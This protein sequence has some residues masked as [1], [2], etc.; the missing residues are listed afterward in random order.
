[1]IRRLPLLVP[2][3][4]LVFAPHAVRT[5]E[6]KW[7]P[8]AL[9]RVKRVTS[10]VPSP[11][12]TRVAFVVSRAVMEGEKSEW[13]SQIHIAASDGSTSYQL[14][15]GDKSATAPQWSPDGRTVAFLSARGGEKAN[16]FLVR[17]GGG[18]AERITVE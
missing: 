7:S 14:T 5:V 15:Q 4:M 18:E 16:I 11:D 13:L 12:A 8:D 2:V 9:L 10:V 6:P 17:A 1:M 3:L